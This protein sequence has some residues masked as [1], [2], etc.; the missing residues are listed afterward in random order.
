MLAVGICAVVAVTLLVWAVFPNWWLLAIYFW[1][2]IASASFIRLP[3]EP[4]VIYAGSIYQPWIVAL[5]GGVASIGGCTL[6][7]F[8]VKK[9]FQLR[10]IGGIQ[11]STL[12]K[13]AVRCFSWKPWPAIV[14]FSFGPFLPYDAIRVLAP[15]TGYAL[16]RFL[17]ANFVGRTARYYLLAL[18]GAWIS[19]PPVYLLILAAPAILM[20]LAMLLWYRRNRRDQGAGDLGQGV[21]LYPGT[22]A[23]VALGFREL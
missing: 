21:I 12:Y 13:F 5:V 1:Y 17:T 22:S 23:G 4:A 16:I 6:D 9:A 19:L 8:V 14:L 2:S 3:Q 20:P 15:S 11:R 18:G 10:R 7:Y